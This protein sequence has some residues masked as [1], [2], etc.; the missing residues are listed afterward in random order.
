MTAL[1]KKPQDTKC[2]DHRTTSFITHTAKIVVKI[3]RRRVERKIEDVLGEDQF[4]FRRGKETRDASGM[5]KIISE[6]TM[7]IDAEVCVCFIN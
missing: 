5:L 3:L 6:R 2:S 7:E 1:T 4:G